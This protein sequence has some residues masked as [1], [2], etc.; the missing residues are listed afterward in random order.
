MLI[1]F[2]RHEIDENL[3]AVTFQPEWDTNTKLV[4]AKEVTNEKETNDL[5]HGDVNCCNTDIMMCLAR[6]CSCTVM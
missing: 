4:P 5:K 6:D 1:Q 3:Q 2:S